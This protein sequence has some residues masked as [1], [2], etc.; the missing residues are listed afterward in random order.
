MKF[1]SGDNN[2]GDD[3]QESV[4]RGVWTDHTTEHNRYDDL[5]M[6]LYGRAN[7]DSGDVIQ[8]LDVGCS[9]GEAIS[10]FADH[11][12]EHYGVDTNVVGI[13][14]GD[15]VVEDAEEEGNVDEGYQGEAQNLEHFDEGEFDI[16]TSKTLLSRISGDQQTEALRE[17]DRVVRDDGYAC[18]QIDDG[19]NNEPERGESYV[20]TGEEMSEV[21]RETNGF[22]DYPIASELEAY[23]FE[24]FS[25]GI[26]FETRGGEG[27]DHGFEDGFLGGTRAVADSYEEQENKSDENQD[28]IIGS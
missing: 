14:I 20:M 17:I 12:E 23:H 22:S 11:V 2:S 7:F 27:T 18:V 21:S 8:I 5:R 28:F 1:N 25:D 24:K 6:G 10:Y 19:G 15:E 9:N 26:E 3:L 4:E 13:D 16:V